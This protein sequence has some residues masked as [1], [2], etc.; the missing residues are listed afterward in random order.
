MVSK[1]GIEKCS[2]SYG[3]RVHGLRQ[4]DADTTRRR[5]RNKPDENY[6]RSRNSDSDEDIVQIVEYF[7]CYE[8]W[9]KIEDCTWSEKAHSN[10]EVAVGSPLNPDAPT[11]RVVLMEPDDMEMNSSIQAAFKR[12]FPELK[13]V[14]DHFTVL[15]QTTRIKSKPSD[16][17]AQRVIKCAIPGTVGELW[18]VLKKIQL[19]ISNDI[20]VGMHHINMMCLDKF[21][22]LVEAIFHG[23]KTHGIIYTNS[24][25][26]KSNKE[27]G[28]FAKSGST[29]RTGSLDNQRNCKP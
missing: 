4:T 12:R 24:G 22:K 1:W 29:H 19:E 15:E 5:L 27:K 26:V 6:C 9:A 8:K 20:S 11:I 14:E 13:E 28:T 25:K 23:S 21:R 16:T 17:F 18:K 3:E 7:G 2:D 10:T